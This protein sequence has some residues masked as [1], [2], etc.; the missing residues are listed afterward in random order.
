M[1]AGQGVIPIEIVHEQM[2]AGP[3][4]LRLQLFDGEGPVTGD[5]WRRHRL[6]FLL[7]RAGD[8]QRARTRHKTT[9]ST[10][11]LYYDD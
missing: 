7:R 10:R 5:A 1:D 9:N 8:R 4:Q 2:A 11:A 6:D 3:T